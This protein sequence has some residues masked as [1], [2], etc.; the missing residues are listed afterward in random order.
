LI[1]DTNRTARR[2]ASLLLGTPAL[3]SRAQWGGLVDA[4]AAFDVIVPT[5]SRL[6]AEAMISNRDIGFV[7]A[8]QAQLR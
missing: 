1:F 6:E 4:G 8:G 7:S 5:D 2:K 3:P